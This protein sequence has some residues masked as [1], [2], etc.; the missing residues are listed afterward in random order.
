MRWIWCLAVFGI[1]LSSGCSDQEAGSDPSP[2][3]EPVPEEKM[4]SEPLS[5]SPSVEVIPDQPVVSEVASSPDIPQEPIRSQSAEPE[6]QAAV[7]E[8][9][10][11]SEITEEVADQETG[12]SVS[13]PVVD[14]GSGNYAKSTLLTTGDIIPSAELADLDG[15]H[16]S[17]DALRAASSAMVILFW[18]SGTPYGSFAIKS[19]QQQVVN[20][21]WEKVQVVA[22]NRGQP[23]EKVREIMSGLEL[24]F[25]VLLDEEGSYFSQFATETVPRMYLVSSEGKILWL[26]VPFRGSQTIRLLQQ[27]IQAHLQDAS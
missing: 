11:R 13:M 23:I 5:P 22:I 8:V 19:L 25:P 2:V 3:P 12:E 9:V 17:I 4:V 21:E 16:Q 18:D 6:Q 1:V 26:D 24:D 27:A 15:M 7:N 14:L 10:S 20:S